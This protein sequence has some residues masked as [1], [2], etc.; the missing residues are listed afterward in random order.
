MKF[1]SHLPFEKQMELR[2]DMV[3]VSRGICESL[4][5]YLSH[6]LHVTTV[7]TL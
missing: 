6:E 5:S 4:L 3:G 7:A 1:I 2:G